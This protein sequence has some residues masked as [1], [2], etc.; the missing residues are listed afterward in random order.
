MTE[1]IPAYIIITTYTVYMVE[2]VVDKYITH[3]MPYRCDRC[4][5]TQPCCYNMRT[6]NNLQDLQSYVHG[7]HE[8]G[9]D[10]KYV[11]LSRTKVVDYSEQPL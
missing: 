5:T 4:D 2:R 6:Y 9:T 8:S 3:E 10:V 1:R 7:I 11:D